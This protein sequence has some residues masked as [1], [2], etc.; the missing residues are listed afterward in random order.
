MSDEDQCLDA[1]AVARFVE[2]DFDVEQCREIEAHL[3][4]CEAC[5]T[6][7]SAVAFA[8]GTPSL[9]E[10]EAP[11]TVF[12]DEVVARAGVSVGRYV[13]LGRLGAG[14]MG[15]VAKAYDPE[16]DRHVAIKILRQPLTS[17]TARRRL[18]REAR[19]MARV[20]HP[21][22]VAIHDV[23]V[24]ED[25]LF[26]AM[27]LVDGVDLATWVRQQPRSVEEILE[28]CRA[29]G[30]GIVEAHAC[31]LVHRDLKPGNVLV[32]RDGAPK[33]AD[34][35]LAQSVGTPGF[36]APEQY[37][38]GAVDARTDQFGFC[39]TVFAA[40]YGVPPFRGETTAETRRAT[41]Q[42][43]RSLP[44]RNDE[45]P[46]GVRRVLLRGLRPNPAQRFASMGALLTELSPR[47]RRGRVIAFAG[48]TVL[49]G[50]LGLQYTLARPSMDCSAGI[51]QLDAVWNEDARAKIGDAFRVTA[52][53]YAHAAAE[54][55]GH[56]IDEA[57]ADWTEAHAETC[58]A[59][60]AGRASA[61]LTK[62]RM[63][64]LERRRH[65]IEVLLERLETADAAVV[66]R[67]VSAAEDLEDPH[68][69]LDRGL[70]IRAREAV[71][72]QMDP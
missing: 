33:V 67:A 45:V 26:I 22:V 50:G 35:G 54:R 61:G 53:A 42:G 27:E 62:S 2:G 11:P 13:L 41:E 9:E 48:L 56:V 72:T 23:G 52:V 4:R 7:V 29:V 20:T 19:A 66:R 1:D 59:W 21:N 16:L 60:M 18:L 24:H 57:V 6:W 63:D 44:T 39:A 68:V 69:C 38:G 46:P 12:P 3:D 30:R 32:P 58:R 65:R 47:P 55:T 28:V 5:R 34:F 51:E 49:V 31:G 17:D 40:L 64:C 10:P 36:M 14:G 15:V 25:R 8:E 70:D 37:G 43:T 71:Q